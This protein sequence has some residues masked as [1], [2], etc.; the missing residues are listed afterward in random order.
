MG[1]IEVP[2][3]PMARVADLVTTETHDGVLIYDLISHD[4]HQV[5]TTA[6]MVWRLCDGSRSPADLAAASELEIDAVELALEQLSD[7]SLLEAS[8]PQLG[9]DRGRAPVSVTHS[10]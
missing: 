10:H 5:N 8:I 2:S 9:A 7:A 1:S 4:L 3:T 6:S